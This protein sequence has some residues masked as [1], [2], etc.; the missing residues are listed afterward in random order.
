MA[1]QNFRDYL[2]P[3]DA[4]R[5][6]A[7]RGVTPAAYAQRMLA[8]EKAQ[9]L[10]AHW[11]AL[12]DEE[13]R[14]I[15]AQGEIQQGLF[16]LQ[17]EGFAVEYAVAAAKDLLGTLSETQR[18]RVCHDIDAQQWRAWYNPEIPFNDFGVRLEDTQISTREAFWELLRSC[19][20]PV[21]FDK[22]RQLMDA[23]HFLGE[24]YDLNNVMN[25]WSFHF[26]MFGTPSLT[27][28]WGWNIYGHHVAFCCFIIGRQLVIAPTFM[29]V[30]PN[31]IDRG[32]SSDC[33]LFTEE[34]RLGLELMQSLSQE[35]QQRA[36]I[37]SLMEDPL[38]PPERFNFA[39][40]RHLAGAFQDNRVIPL[41]GISAA[42]FNAEQQD[43]LLKTIEAFINFLPDGP[44]HARMKLV[45]QY[46]DETWWN[47][48]GGCGDDDVYYYRIQSPVIL[49]EFDHH[50]GM[51]LTNEEPAKFHIH[52][53]TRIPNGNDYGKALLSFWKK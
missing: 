47:W 51:W 16:P 34:E 39:D 48:I 10:K 46:L 5:I 14:G 31:I 1:S 6:A 30:E 35:Q 37:Y 3:A 26:M 12:L 21:G 32:N 25:R 28:P 27:A 4:P 19:T 45:E 22:V 43:K 24:L 15:T 42:E 50:S 44:R 18:K 17:D 36:T 53:I 29:G 11:Q 9:N 20:S 41:E 23:N 7:A 52:T 40:Q 8:T 2:L 49:L 13:F 38:M 33:I